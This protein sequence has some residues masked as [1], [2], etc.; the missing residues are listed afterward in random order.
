MNKT[1]LLRWAN[2]SSEKAPGTEPRRSQKGGSVFEDSLE[3]D[4]I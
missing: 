1:T 3:L 4:T 2:T